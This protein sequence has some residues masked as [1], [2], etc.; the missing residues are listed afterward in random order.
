MPVLTIPKPLRAVLGEEGA[1]S[2]VEVLREW[3][4]GTKEDVISLSAEKFE[5]R[6]TEEATRLDKRITEEISRLRIELLE[7][8]GR[9]FRWITGI[10]L[11]TLIPMWTSII[12]VVLFKG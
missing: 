5:R 10:L 8:M 6:L 4:R 7:K 9:D 3:E 12:L 1:D 11:G 2:L